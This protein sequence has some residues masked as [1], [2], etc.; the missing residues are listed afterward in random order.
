MTNIATPSLDDF[1]RAILKIA[2][3]DNQF[4]HA[5][6][7]ERVGLSASAVRRRLG[8]LRRSGV[9]ARDVAILD[10][11]AFGVT[12]IVTVSFA[13]E[14]L[15][16][17]ATFE[18]AMQSLPNVRQCYHVAGDNDYVLVVQA[19]TLPFYEEWAKQ[20]I[21]SNDAIRRYDTVVVWSCKKF[22]TAI[23]LD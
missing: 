9:I 19:P 20:H 22:E 2:Q 8:I 10:P 1:D 23:P 13:I 7:G 12:L 16:I 11:G 4:S 18:R 21:M 14:S 15:D 3:Q 17:Y 6:I 5:A